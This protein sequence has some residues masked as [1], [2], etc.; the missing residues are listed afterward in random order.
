M[1]A[2]ARPC[3]RYSA[4]VI[5]AADDEVIVG[6]RRWRMLTALTEAGG[7]QSSRDNYRA[8]RCP[9]E[10]NRA[11]CKSHW[12][13]VSAMLELGWISSHGGI[14]RLRSEG[15][16]ALQAANARDAAETRARRDAA[17]WARTPHHHHE[18][19]AR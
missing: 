2:A 19:H 16:A 7:L 11:N 18:E 12:K 5:A 4:T 8:T 17:A 15:R 13:Q 14:L 1:T 9:S 3:A 10:S 6:R